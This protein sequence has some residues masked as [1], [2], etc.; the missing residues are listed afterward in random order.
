[1]SQREVLLGIGNQP[2]LTIAGLVL[3]MVVC[4]VLEL[5]LVD[6]Y[7]LGP[8][9]RLVDDEHSAE[10]VFVQAVADRVRRSQSLLHVVNAMDD[11]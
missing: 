6:R 8:R 10:D 4:V 5:F 7:F 9:A 11:I 1:M 3:V 2:V